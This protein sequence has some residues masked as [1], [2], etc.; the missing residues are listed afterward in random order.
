[1]RRA[2]MWALGLGLGV[3]A[4]ALAAG[5]IQLRLQSSR[6]RAAVEQDARR[7]IPPL[8]LLVDRR[9]GR[10]RPLLENPADEDHPAIAVL[11]DSWVAGLDVGSRKRTPGML[12]A[13]GLSRLLDEDV[14]LR[15]VAEP[16]AGADD[17]LR[18]VSTVLADRRMRRSRTGASRPRYAVLS[19]GTAD[20]VHPI[21]GSIGLPVL[22]TA[23]NRLQR[24]GGYRVLVLTVPNL[25]L[26]PLIG[27]PL[28]DV[29]RRSS[30]VL[31][32][33]QW[34]TAVSTGALPVS[35]NRTLAGTSRI[36]LLSPGGRSPS[37][38]DTT[39]LA[40]AVLR[41]I[42][43]DLELPVEVRPAPEPADDSEELPA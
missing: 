12:L 11:G 4:L 21:S 34:L 2:T 39:Q 9:T 35:L 18:Q 30:R 19:M 3:P 15:V 42:A 27:R 33:S 26:L 7:P 8:A 32:G 43:E 6:L 20:L 37:L 1:M 25:G 5:S 28:R 10:G 17:V 36:G 40:A 38:L 22:S 29:L 31:S 14:R 23:I 13:R 16:S 24:E 41:R